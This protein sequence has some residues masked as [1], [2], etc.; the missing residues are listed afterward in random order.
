MNKYTKNG[1][2]ITVIGYL[3]RLFVYITRLLRLSRLSLPHSLFY[4]FSLI[5]SHFLS[6]PSNSFF[7]VSQRE[8]PT[9]RKSQRICSAFNWLVLHW[10]HFLTPFYACKRE[11]DRIQCEKKPTSQQR[12]YISIAMLPRFFFLFLS[13]C[14][15][16]NFHII[17]NEV[18]MYTK[19]IIT[20]RKYKRR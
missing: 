19:G 20:Q 15:F 1:F 17:K 7:N 14:F 11:Q 4:S 18:I 13:V 8:Q 16:L 9:V 12:S 2:F 5:L 6:F 10:P 3:L